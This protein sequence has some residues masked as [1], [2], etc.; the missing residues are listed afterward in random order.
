MEGP[1]NKE[2]T[3]AKTVLNERKEVKEL[4]VSKSPCEVPSR[5]APHK[6]ALQ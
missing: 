6:V 3:Q 2:V 1:Q 5:M 4:E